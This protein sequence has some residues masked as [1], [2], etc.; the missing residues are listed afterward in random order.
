[1]FD[2]CRI[3]GPEGLDWSTSYAK[4]GDRGDTGHVIVLRN[5]R[6]WRLD[7]AQNG[8]I[9]STAELEQYVRDASA[10]SLTR[11]DLYF[12]LADRSSTS[13]TAPRTSIPASAS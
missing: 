5:G 7:A 4:A 12:M 3:P 10:S 1:M 2:C 6:F 8:R 13:S 11:L 9:L